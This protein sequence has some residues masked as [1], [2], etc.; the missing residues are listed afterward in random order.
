[1]PFLLN[2]LTAYRVIEGRLTMKDEFGKQCDLL[3]S[4]P[5]M[6]IFLQ[7]YPLALAFSVQAHKIPSIRNSFQ[8]KEGNHSMKDNL[9]VSQNRRDWKRPLEFI[10]FN[11]PAGMILVSKVVY[12]TILQQ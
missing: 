5:I 9:T 11:P 7:Y 4:F 10:E 8:K 3:V 12:F 6:P 2:N 1:M